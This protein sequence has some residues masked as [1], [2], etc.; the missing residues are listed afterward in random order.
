MKIAMAQ[1]NPIVGDIKGNLARLIETMNK[2]KNDKLDLVVFPELFLTGYPPQGLLERSWFVKTAL[3][4]VE[5]V[6]QK[7]QEDAR[8]EIDDDGNE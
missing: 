4:A 6:A 2:H 5:E 3:D 1:L 7:P 8:D